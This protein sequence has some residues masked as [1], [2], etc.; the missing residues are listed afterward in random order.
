LIFSLCLLG[1]LLMS[2]FSFVNFVSAEDIPGMPSELNPEQLEETVGSLSEKWE[3]LAREWK[4]ILLGNSVVKA[5]DSFLQKINIVFVVLF[6]KDYSMSLALLLIIFFWVFLLFK[7][8][9]ILRDFTAFPKSIA[10][11]ISLCLVIIL[12]QFKLLE[13]LASFVILIVFG[14]KPWWLSLLIGLL[15]LMGVVFAG[16]FISKFGAQIAENRRKRKEQIER[17]K[18]ESGANVGESMTKAAADG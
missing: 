13:K 12:A 10:I 8:N 18:L 4:N 3:Y 5:I 1:L 7:F 11:V 14:E 17:I 6:A 15:I 2:F 9:R 16:V